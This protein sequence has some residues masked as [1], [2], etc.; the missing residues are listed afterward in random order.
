MGDNM[1][2]N[3]ILD[4]NTL[5]ICE[6]NIKNK[7]LSHL[8]KID[9]IYN[10]KF[11]SINDI[12]KKLFFDYDKEAIYYLMNKYNFDYEVSKTYIEN[13]YFITDDNYESD[14]LNE[15]LK[16]KSEL[17]NN[18]LLILDPLFKDYI[19]SKNIKVVMK[20]I[21]KYHNYIFDILRNYTN[22]DIYNF[23]YNNYEHKVYEFDNIDNEIEYVAYNI[24]DL[25]K[26]GIDINKIKISNID[27]DYITSIKRIFNSFNI[28]INMPSNSF[29]IGTKIGQDFINNIKSDIN[30]TIN[31]LE[32]YNG[33]PIYDL[34]IDICNKYSF[35]DDYTKVK[36]LI[37]YDLSNTLVPNTKYENAIEIIDYNDIIDDDTYVFLM[38][39]NIKSI[40]KV[41]KDEDFLSDVIKPEFLDT[42]LE[43]NKL[44]K[45]ITIKSIDNI[46]NL[47]IT[48]K[49]ITPTSECYPSILIENKLVEKPKI[50]INKSYSSLNDKLK[51]SSYLDKYNKYGYKDNNLNILNYNYDI[52]YM[53]YDNKYNKVN[54][55]NLYDFVDSKLLFSYTSVE[56]YNECA[57]KY[58]L[59]DILKID[60]Y[61]ENFSALIGTLFHYILQIGINKDINI[62][63][64][65]DK[66]LKEKYKDKVFTKKELF[67]IDNIKEN[68]S[69]ALSTI[70][71][72]MKLS[73]LKKL[74]LEEAIYISKDK[75]LKI[76]FKGVIDKIMYEEENNQTIMAI[77]D[78]KTGNF[79]DID[80]GYMTY[81]IGLQLPIYLYLSSNM[82][83]KNIR[84][85][86]IYLQKV[87]T[88]LN[89]KDEKLKLEGYSNSD[90]SIIEK[91]DITYKD[92]EVIKSLK[93]IK[94]GSFS[95]NSKILDDNKFNSL[96]SLANDKINETIDNVLD[97]N[98]DINPIKKEN[99]QSVTACEFCN[100]K[101][102][103][104]RK[105]KDIRNLKKDKN[106]S[107]LGGDICD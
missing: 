43:K 88:D 76:T 58:Y 4:D 37:R 67:F 103:C 96:I 7:I 97:A 98:F 104:F 80:L 44:E 22:I 55:D 85:A 87:M 75:N 59:S 91:F 18:N 63:E 50:N 57:F 105:N 70:K 1:N 23:K 84:F 36:N 8:N 94:D 106:L 40:P 99:S 81:G 19:K 68:I 83:L 86:G 92:S 12:I 3:D 69:F 45:N 49:N 53:K 26:K 52:P 102:I 101:D 27:D 48:F 29:L 24:C 90:Q 73:K 65:I 100:F 60:I 95:A 25:I 20:K 16:L 47:I 30:E 56:K 77:I 89:N 28:P 66:F 61:E 72:Q 15:L 33:S 10:I 79:V 42:T 35:I 82:N 5:I 2:Y 11:M 71:N 6:S 9:N 107:F 38:N 34:I 62:D 17:L 32:K 39:F 13:M 64:E 54:K 31:I 74:K 41:Y 93:T 78:Y 14:K 51:L 21:S 46:K